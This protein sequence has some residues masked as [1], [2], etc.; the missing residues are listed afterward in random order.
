M[1]LTNLGF[2]TSRVKVSEDPDLKKLIL[3]IKTVFACRIYFIFSF[4]FHLFNSCEVRAV[5]YL[6]PCMQYAAVMTQS[7]M[8]GL[9]LIIIFIVD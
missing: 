2:T 9:H 4:L 1:S 5:D 7:W 8:V 3:S 6:A